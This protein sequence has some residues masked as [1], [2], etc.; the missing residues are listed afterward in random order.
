[1]TPKLTQY[2][3]RSILVSIP[4]LFDDGRCRPFRLLGAEIHGLWLQSDE[5]TGRLHPEKHGQTPAR[6]AAFIPFAQIGAVLI[7]PPTLSATTVQNRASLAHGAAHTAKER[8]V[9]EDAKSKTKRRK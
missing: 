9:S 2:L 3:N 8:F 6:A 4:V 5:L 7:T 1:M